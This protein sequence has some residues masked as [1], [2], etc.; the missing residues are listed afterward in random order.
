MWSSTGRGF[1]AST[2]IAMG[3]AAAGFHLTAREPRGNEQWCQ[4]LPGCVCR[5]A[6]YTSMKLSKSFGSDLSFSC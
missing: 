2:A 5:L 6:L 1:A 3:S 4:E